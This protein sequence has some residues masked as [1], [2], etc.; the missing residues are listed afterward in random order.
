MGHLHL[1]QHDTLFLV[2]GIPSAS[3]FSLKLANR[4]SV[5][6]G[7]A[8][9]QFARSAMHQMRTSSFSPLRTGAIFCLSITHAVRRPYATLK[10]PSHPGRSE[11]GCLGKFAYA[12]YSVRSLELRCGKSASWARSVLT[13]ASSSAFAL[14]PCPHQIC[15]LRDSS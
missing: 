11:C 1:S 8:T 14:S 12:A 7:A 15:F 9:G 5:L 13:P 6:P 2:F 10:S 4:E 3:S